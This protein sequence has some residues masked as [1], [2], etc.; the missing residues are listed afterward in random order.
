MKGGQRGPSEPETTA[1]SD[2]ARGQADAPAQGNRRG[3]A[4][5]PEPAAPAA[6]AAS[7]RKRE[8]PAPAGTRGGQSS[9]PSSGL[10]DSASDGNVVQLQRPKRP[11]R[12]VLS[13]VT[14]DRTVRPR[15]APATV[16]VLQG[17]PMAT[18]VKS[19]TDA[20]LRKT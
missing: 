3:G 1:G 18:A 20:L 14:K 19:S 4:S 7:Q 8:V 12:R 6:P 16:R 11:K 10:T 9:T 2:E 17:A 13:G 15:N 5:R